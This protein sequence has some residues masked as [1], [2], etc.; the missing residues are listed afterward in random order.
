VYVG[1]SLKKQSRAQTKWCA[2]S[3][4]GL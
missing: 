1:A 2:Q 4:K 3:R